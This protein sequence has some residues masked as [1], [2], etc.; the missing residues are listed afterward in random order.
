MVV[1]REAEGTHAYTDC[2]IRQRCSTRRSARMMVRAYPSNGFSPTPTL[3]LS[4]FHLL[5]AHHSTRHLH[6]ACTAAPAL[7]HVRQITSTVYRV[8]SISTHLPLFILR[9]TYRFRMPCYRREG[10]LCRLQL[11][12]V[13]RTGSTRCGEGRAYEG[14]WNC[15]NAAKVEHTRIGWW[16]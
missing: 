11:P 3:S 7:V 16:R 5:V 15:D 8:L 9:R 2:R 1:G 6:C 14:H 4:V 10:W 12:A 13:G